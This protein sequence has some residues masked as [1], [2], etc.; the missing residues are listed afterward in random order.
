MAAVALHFAWNLSAT[1]DTYLW[2]G[3]CLLIMIPSALVLGAIL[4]A[5]LARE[6]Q[7]LRRYLRHDLPSVEL[8]TVSSILGRVRFSLTALLRQ[9][10]RDWKRSE[11]FLQAASQLAFLRRGR[12]E[13]GQ[14]A[15]EEEEEALRNRMYAL[16]SQLSR[17]FARPH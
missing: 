3:T 15:Q 8:E 14:P 16:Q 10:P 4:E 7:C 2:Y 11:D 9:G 1:V 6:G 5:A 17:R 13:R 12:E